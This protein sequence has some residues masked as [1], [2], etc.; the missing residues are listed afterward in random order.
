M[1]YI[2]LLV[3]N[4]GNS[5]KSFGIELD[6]KCPIC[7]NFMTFKIRPDTCFHYFCIECISKW[8]IIKKVCPI[9]KA[10]FSNLTL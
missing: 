4:I 6:K 3:N 9:C 2:F 5:S 1:K 10:S 7:L 8:S